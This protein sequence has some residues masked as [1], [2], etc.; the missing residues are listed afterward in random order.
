M[1]LTIGAGPLAGD[2]ARGTNYEIR[3][4][5]RLLFFGDFPRRVRARFN[6]HTVLD[7]RRGRLLHESTLLP[8][9]YVPD[10][11]V[12]N[13]VLLPSEH[14]TY[15]PFKGHARYRSLSVGQRSVPNA[16]WAYPE[17][18]PEAEWLRGH[19]AFFWEG[20]DA[21]YDEGERVE[22]HLRDPFHRVD[23]REFSGVVRVTADAEVLVETS[24]AK[25]L[26]ETGLPNRFY[27]PRGDVRIDLVASPK[28]TV[29]PY[30]GTA[31]YWSAGT[32]RDVGWSYERPLDDA[33]RVKGHVSFDRDEVDV[34]V[35]AD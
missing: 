25:V 6:D 19:T 3:G 28:S 30:K 13:D 9:L 7:T 27:V 8:V 33:T 22:G 35:I 10:D 2:A 14:T 32:R 29:C 31:S 5:E 20:M 15:C 12:D 26:S 1:G 4:P 34:E 17:P 21:W 18:N 24:R 23:V 16:A 11:D